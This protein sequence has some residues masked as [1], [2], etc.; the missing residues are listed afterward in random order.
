VSDK[1][2]SDTAKATLRSHPEL[3]NALKR[4]WEMGIGEASSFVQEFYR[5]VLSDKRQLDH[6]VSVIAGNFSLI[7]NIPDEILKHP[8]VSFNVR[9][10]LNEAILDGSAS[11]HEDASFRLLTNR[12]LKLFP[13]LLWLNIKRD[14]ALAISDFAYNPRALCAVVGA[15]SGK[16]VSIADTKRLL[17][18]QKAAYIL[19]ITEFGRFDN[20]YELFRNRYQIAT[21]EIQQKL[22]ESLGEAY[23]KD[24]AEDSRPICVVVNPARYADHNG[25][26]LSRIDSQVHIDTIDQLTSHYHV[27]YYEAS[28][29]TELTRD[30]LSGFAGSEK[31]IDVLILGGHGHAEGVQLGHGHSLLK[32]GSGELDITDV[33]IFRRLGTLM[34][35]G[36]RVFLESCSTAKDNGEDENVATVIHRHM[37]TCH[38]FAPKSDAGFVPEFNDDGE[39]IGANYVYAREAHF[40][41]DGTVETESWIGSIYSD[42]SLTVSA[43]ARSMYLNPWDAGKTFLMVIGAQVLLAG[44]YRSIRSLFKS[45]ATRRPGRSG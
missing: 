41:P 15:D 25:A 11:T 8:R 37:P 14:D 3:M 28:D 12:S 26:F 45:R 16:T 38:V 36:G 7:E 33:Q 30:M 5:E 32:K 24:I 4:R 19:N 40:K 18:L 20:A 23:F 34:K 10:A 35:E 22:R 1:E 29:E 31:L 6:I 39:L 42:I 9:K 44:T 13:E 27:I 21:P 43:T 17:D 2:I